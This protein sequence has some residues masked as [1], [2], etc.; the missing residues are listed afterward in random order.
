M[1]VRCCCFVGGGDLVGRS[2]SSGRTFRSLWGISGLISFRLFRERYSS[3]L[4][5][6]GVVA[7]SWFLGRTCSGLNRLGTRMQSGS[8][9]FGGQ[10]FWGLW[11]VYFPRPAASMRDFVS[12]KWWSRRCWHFRR[13]QPWAWCG[14]VHPSDSS[15]PNNDSSQMPCLTMFFAIAAP[16]LA[17]N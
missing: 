14:P 7:R 4:G 15:Q 9:Y 3:C 6:R 16:A 5:C 13:H 2:C 1:R 8:Q 10:R 11:L 17:G 12:G